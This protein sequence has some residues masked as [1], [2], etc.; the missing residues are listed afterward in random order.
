M[1][2][3]ILSVVAVLLVIYFFLMIYHEESNR[4]LPLLMP[5]VC[6]ALCVFA[7]ITITL[8]F[9]TVVSILAGEITSVDLMILFGMIVSVG[10]IWFIEKADWIHY[11]ETGNHHE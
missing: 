10:T 5:V 2:D 6:S 11:I 4:A 8:I 9:Y 7:S 3:M 1:N